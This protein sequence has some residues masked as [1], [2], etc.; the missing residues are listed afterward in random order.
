MLQAIEKPSSAGSRSTL[1]CRSLSKPRQLLRNVGRSYYGLL[2]ASNK[3]TISNTISDKA[4]SLCGVLVHGYLSDTDYAN[5]NEDLEK[6]II[7]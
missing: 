3:I 2:G 6:G 5:I 7:T 4:I 1:S